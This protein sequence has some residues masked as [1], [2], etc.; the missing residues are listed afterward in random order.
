LAAPTQVPGVIGGP[1]TDPGRI[2]V[3]V[4]QGGSGG[5]RG[6]FKVRELI[7]VNIAWKSSALTD[8]PLWIRLDD[9]GSI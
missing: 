3:L 5:Y 7:G 1:P 8:E 6:G 2:P 4:E 9:P